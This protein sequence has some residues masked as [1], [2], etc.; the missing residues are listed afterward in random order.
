MRGM[1]LNYV[2]LI[3]FGILS[4]RN[5]SLIFREKGTVIGFGVWVYTIAIFAV[6]ILV[7][8]ATIMGMD[9]DSLRIYIETSF[10]P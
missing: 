1:T 7:L 6:F 3:V 4:I 2:L 10:R 5:F 8:V 9:Y